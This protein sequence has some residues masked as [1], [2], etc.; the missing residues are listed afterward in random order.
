MVLYLATRKLDA[1]VN[2]MI[3][4]LYSLDGFKY[5]L[6]SSATMP[7]FR[8]TKPEKKSLST[9]YMADSLLRPETITAASLVPGV[10][11]AFDTMLL[12]RTLSSTTTSTL[13]SALGYLKQKMGV[14]KR[15]SVIG[16]FDS[17]AV[18]QM[19]DGAGAGASSQQREE[20]PA[21]SNSR[22][23][24]QHSSDGR[25]AM[26]AGESES[27][28]VSGMTF[29]AHSSPFALPLPSYGGHS[30]PLNEL[31]P[32]D[33]CWA[34]SVPLARAS[35][36]LMLLTDLVAAARNFPHWCLHLPLLLNV[37][38]LGIAIAIGSH[39]LLPSQCSTSTSALATLMCNVQIHTRKSILVRLICM[40]PKCLLLRLIHLLTC[41]SHT[42]SH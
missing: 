19:R 29:Y 8:Y 25:L 16:A 41:H 26:G 12:R 22:E 5:N 28:S 10:E 7:Y 1:V 37:I 23:Q 34:A 2:E 27:S 13:S 36:L 21:I 40:R 17:G 3:E 24:Q 20:G 35:V 6:E 9:G 33:A 31:M 38:L 18:L 32:P 4:E 11:D 30:A 39:P 42:N 14:N 15:L